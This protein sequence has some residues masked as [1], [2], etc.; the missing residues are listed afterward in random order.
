VT[1]ERLAGAAS[2]GE[3]PDLDDRSGRGVDLRTVRGER[4]RAEPA[5][6]ADLAAEAAGGQVVLGVA[7]R[8]PGER[9]GDDGREDEADQAD[10]DD[11]PPVGVEVTGRR[12]RGF[13][14]LAGF[15]GPARPGRGTRT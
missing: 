5:L 8:P 15:T 4:D 13:G 6:R 10:D 12:A 14:G 1:G 9:A 7:G 2:R 11:R 3:V